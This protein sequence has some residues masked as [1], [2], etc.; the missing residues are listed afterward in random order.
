MPKHRGHGEGSINQRPSGRWQAQVCIDG[1]RLTETL[2]S[3]SEALAWVREQQTR[4]AQGLI[5]VDTRNAT[6]REFLDNWF[7]AVQPTVKPR[8]YE[9]YSD[10]IRL[11]IAPTLGRYR[12]ADL[13]PDHLQRLYAE[14]LKEGLSAR[15]VQIA[16]A[17]LRHALGDACAWGFVARNVCLAAK[18]PR[19]KRVELNAWTPEEARQFLEGIRGERLEG[20]YRL[21]LACGPRAG[22][23]VGLKWEDVDLTR[24]TVQ[25]RRTLQRLRGQGIVESEPKTDRARRQVSL[26][27]PVVEALKRWKVRQIEERL[28]AGETWQ[29]SGYLFTTCKGSP[30][31]PRNLHR[32]FTRKTERLGLPRLRL[33][34]LRHTAATLLLSRGIHP[35]V[36]QE[37]LGHSQITLTMDTYSHVLPTMQQEAAQVMEELLP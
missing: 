7:K 3:K 24:G 18:A 2:P 36:V 11:H 16:H 23:L 32:D 33:H 15:T 1:Q 21:A 9:Q 31:E 34:D 12:L 14:K 30:I 17:V 10:A 6:L 28:I 37:M 5:L 13:R 35:K 25:I 8:T 4:A 22:E 26:P 20:L 19:P 29:D 27:K